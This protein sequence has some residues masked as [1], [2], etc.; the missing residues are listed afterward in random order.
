MGATRLCD[1]NGE[2]KVNI[3]PEPLS[4]VGTV[5]FEEGDG[6]WGDGG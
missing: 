4:Q 5:A 1:T 3:P 6:G 2:N